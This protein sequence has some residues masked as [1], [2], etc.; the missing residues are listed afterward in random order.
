MTNYRYMSGFISRGGKRGL[1]PP[2]ETGLP[3]LRNLIVGPYNYMVNTEKINDV[4]LLSTPLLFLN[5]NDGKRLPSK[6]DVRNIWSQ[7]LPEAVSESV[8]LKNFL[9]EHAPRPP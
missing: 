5:E 8:K 2:L 6:T 7:K 4:R 9:G 1:L 3:P